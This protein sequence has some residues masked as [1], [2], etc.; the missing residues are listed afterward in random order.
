MVQASSTTPEPTAS[1]A[2][3]R[4]SPVQCLRDEALLRVRRHPWLFLPAIRLSHRL[5]R[6]RALILPDAR[7]DLVVEGFFR[8][9][10]H[11]VETAL[12]LAQHDDIRLACKSHAAAVVIHA[13]RR[14]LPTLILVRDPRAVTLSNHLKHPRTTL[15]HTLR[16][17]IDFH[18]RILPHRQRFVVAT[19]EQVTHDL[20]PVI[21][22]LNARFDLQLRRLPPPEETARL[23]AQ[24]MGGDT[25]RR[26]P[27][28][29]AAVADLPT[30]EKD[31]AK[32]AAR[33]RLEAPSLRPL[34]ERAEAVHEQF[35]RETQE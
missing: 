18:Q 23:L 3:P 6:N 19:F 26:R 16:G 4:L 13:C 25:L 32:E 15:A 14:G 12:R 30:P 2:P 20:N 17:Y 33:A 5:G 22:Q 10:N 24:R 7:T 28:Q 29:G 31:R 21:D 1:P 8:S 11:Y 34:L 27:L 9:A 35:L